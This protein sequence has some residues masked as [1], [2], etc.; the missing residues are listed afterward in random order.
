M[1]LYYLIHGFMVRH[2]IYDLIMYHII[3]NSSD[4]CNMIQLCY[5]SYNIVSYL[6]YHD[7]KL[8]CQLIRYNIIQ[9]CILSY[10]TKSWYK[11]I[12][13]DQDTIIYDTILY[14]TGSYD[15]ILNDMTQYQLI[16]YHMRYDIV[17]FNIISYF[18]IKYY[19]I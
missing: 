1:I 16:E 18:T 6:L 14:E 10:Y 5:I 17:W 4:L 15:T 8:Y 9:H 3:C 2:F 13:R 11:N 12:I 19:I 7:I